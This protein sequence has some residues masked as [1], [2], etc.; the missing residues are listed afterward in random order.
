MVV[1]I[2]EEMVTLPALQLIA[3]P[4]YQ[5]GRVKAK[6]CAKKLNP[7]QSFLNLNTIDLL[8]LGGGGDYPLK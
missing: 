5:R 2:L 4:N 6:S 7:E 8:N 1:Q 3:F